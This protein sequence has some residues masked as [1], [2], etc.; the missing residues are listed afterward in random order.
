M[1]KK[2]AMHVQS[3]CF[4]NHTYCFFAVLVTV[5]VDVSCLSSL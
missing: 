5:A 1:Y 4:A 3:C 2:S